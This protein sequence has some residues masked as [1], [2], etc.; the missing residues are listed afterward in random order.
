MKPQPGLLRI[1]EAPSPNHVERP[2][3]I[4]IDMLVLHYTG[5]HGAQAA[6]DRLR[7]PQARVSSHYVVEEEDGTVWRLVDERRQAF[8]AGI[9]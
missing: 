3:G 2:P 8:H 4:S 9:S 7:D 6:I 1:R 5:M